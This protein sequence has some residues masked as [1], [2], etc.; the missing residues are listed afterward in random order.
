MTSADGGAD[1]D[2]RDKWLWH[3]YRRAKDVD[4]AVLAE[5]C[6]VEL[7]ELH[8][9]T[10]WVW[11]DLGLFAKRR[12]DWPEC[13]RL[14][15]GSLE[16][17]VESADPAA[18]NL[19]IA[20]TAMGDWATA[21]RAWSTYGVPMPDG[22]G[23]PLL[24]FGMVPI[25][26]NPEPRH[27][28]ESQLLLDGRAHATEVVWCRRIDPARGIIQNVPTPES[29]HRFG[30]LVLHDGEPV[31]TRV[32]GDQERPVF[33]EL[34][35]LRA[36]EDPTL[37]AEVSCPSKADADELE[38]AFLAAGLAA[39][40]WTTGIQFLCKACSEGTPEAGDHVHTPAAWQP[41]RDFGIGASPEAADQLLRAWAL[42]GSD[43]SYGTPERVL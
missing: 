22:D 29:G 3:E 43:R 7:M 20:A 25:R 37:R 24:D 19:G 14:N 40:D 11:F 9:E 8:P 32:L 18:W 15:L 27:I 33:A 12:R 16:I 39:E 41:A 13:A 5:A 17:E 42:S 2:R 38:S 23:E 30:D 34:D 36:A 26:L 6:L 28:G 1:A 4:D 21:R 10:G 31:G 35:L